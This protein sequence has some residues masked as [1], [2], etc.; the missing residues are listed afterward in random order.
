ME[1]YLKNYKSSIY[2]AILKHGH[3]N[4][5]LTILEYCEPSNCLIREK[6]YISLSKSE[7]NIVQD[8]TLNPMSG[9]EHS[10]KTKTIMSDVKKGDKN[11]MFNKP[12]SEG[13]GRPS[14]QIKVTDITNNTT[15]YYDSIREAARALNI[16]SYKSISKYFSNNKQKPY[17][18][19]YTFTKTK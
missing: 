10:E 19:Q 14:Q 5:S 11:P 17:K 12:R 4:F 3:T 1:N 6:H 9:R 2:S 18:G 7:Y 8:P 16:P 15:T 13:A